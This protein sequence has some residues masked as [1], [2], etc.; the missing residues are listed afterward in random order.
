MAIVVPP[1]FGKQCTELIT[2]VTAV[3][4]ASRILIMSKSEADL[5]SA[6]KEQTQSLLLPFK[7]S[8]SGGFCYLL[9]G[10]DFQPVILRSL[11]STT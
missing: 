10:A 1:K 4:G 7:E 11:V 9:C 8:L 5:L 6:S 3:N 2:L